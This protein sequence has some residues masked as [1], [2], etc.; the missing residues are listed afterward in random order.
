MSKLGR[1][2]SFSGRIGENGGVA[3]VG[4]AFSGFWVEVIGPFCD[5]WGGGGGDWV[6]DRGGDCDGVGGGVGGRR[7]REVVLDDRVLLFD[8]RPSS[9]SSP[10]D[11]A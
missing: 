4:R 6:G 2:S 3:I 7:D 5:N 8:D 11:W 1:F 9:V 10:A